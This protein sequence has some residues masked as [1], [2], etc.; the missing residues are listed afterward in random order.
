MKKSEVYK[1]QRRRML[2]VAAILLLLYSAWL[3]YTDDKPRQP[4]PGPQVE[5]PLPGEP[6]A[7][8]GARVD[9]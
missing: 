5:S 3:R 4:P 7:T 2:I 8:Q 1:A 6:S 9:R